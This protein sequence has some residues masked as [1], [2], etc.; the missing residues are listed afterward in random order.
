MKLITTVAGVIYNKKGEILCTKRDAGKYEYVSFKWEFPGGKMEQGENDQQ[1]LSRELME[2]LEIKVEIG[3]K[4]YQVEHDYPDFHLSMALYNCK[5][6]SKDIK[7]NVH[8]EIKWL[9]PQDLMML[10]WASADLPVA[11]AIVR[12][13]TSQSTL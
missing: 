6:L 3:D 12:T 10:D 9:A 11:E 4:F 1:T 13:H 2:E 5:M 8:K 7:M